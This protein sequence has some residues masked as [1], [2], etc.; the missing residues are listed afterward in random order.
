MQPARMGA[1]TISR[2]KKHDP[3]NE[4][5]D[6]RSIVAGRIAGSFP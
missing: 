4:R 3:G 6:S 2:A 1:R 5:L